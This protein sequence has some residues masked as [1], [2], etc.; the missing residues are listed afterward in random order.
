MREPYTVEIDPPAEQ[1]I[2][3]A[4]RWWEQHSP[5]R[6]QLIVDQLEKAYRHLARF[7]AAGAPVQI[8]GRWA[9]TA[10]VLVLDGTGY[11]L[12][13][14]VDDESRQVLVLLLWHE[15]RRRPKLKVRLRQKTKG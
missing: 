4:C 9:E 6:A 1:S 3:E 8:R 2:E 14:D 13:Y 15:K 5:A 7:P 12:Y 10:R 11:G